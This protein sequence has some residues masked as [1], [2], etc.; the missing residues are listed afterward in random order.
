MRWPTPR[1]PHI[2]DHNFAPV[3]PIWDMLFGTA[4]FG[5]VQRPTGVDDPRIDADNGRGWLG[6]QVVVFKRFVA[7]LMPRGSW[8]AQR[9]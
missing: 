3:L 2:H 4:R 7:A 1:E 8:A 5:D 9:R 6:Q